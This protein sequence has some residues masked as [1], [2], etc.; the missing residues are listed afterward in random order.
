MRECT[1]HILET[2]LQDGD[3]LCLE[4][5]G[6]G[7]GEAEGVGAGDE[8]ERRGEGAVSRWGRRKTVNLVGCCEGVEGDDAGGVAGGGL[9]GDFVG[10]GVAARNEVA[11]YC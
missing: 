5:E 9:D 8:G 2:V 3:T 4:R 1:R 10:E 6:D 7:L 11:D